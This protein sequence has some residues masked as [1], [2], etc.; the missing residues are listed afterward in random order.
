MKVLT[1][2]QQ[3]SWFMKFCSAVFAIPARTTSPSLDAGQRLGTAEPLP[4]LK[5]CYSQGLRAQRHMILSWTRRAM[6]VV[7]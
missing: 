3:E 4:R 2:V 1:L 5:H 7:H 6:T